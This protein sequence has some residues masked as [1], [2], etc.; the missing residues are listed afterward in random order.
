M[1]K[2]NLTQ[3]MP[4][5]FASNH[6]SYIDS[7]VMLTVVPVNARFVVKKELFHAPLIRHYRAKTRLSGC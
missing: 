7:L 6:A 2:K 4:V 1:V 5:I 3:T